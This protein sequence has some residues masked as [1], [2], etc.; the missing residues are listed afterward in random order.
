MEVKHVKAREAC[1]EAQA[2]IPVG[3]DNPPGLPR[4]NE[5]GVNTLIARACKLATQELMEGELCRLHA[6]KRSRSNRP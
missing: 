1:E 3:P 6:T 2:K 5:M 4:G